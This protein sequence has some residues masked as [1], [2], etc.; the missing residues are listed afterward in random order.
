MRACAASSPPPPPPPPPLPVINIASTDTHA[1]NHSVPHTPTRTIAS[2][3]LDASLSVVQFTLQI[4]ALALCAIRARLGITQLRFLHQMF[5]IRNSLSKHRARTS[6]V[7]RL[8]SA[9][10][11]DAIGGADDSLRGVVTVCV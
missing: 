9:A 2:R 4:G 8:V 3:S 7:M 10:L 6:S 5:E 1:I 11:L